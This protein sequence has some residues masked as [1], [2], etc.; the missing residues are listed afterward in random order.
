VTTRADDKLPRCNFLTV[1]CPH[2]GAIVLEH[3]LAIPL[4]MLIAYLRRDR[5]AFAR[6][7]K[8]LTK[9]SG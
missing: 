7:P 6:Y 3:G 8:I 1:Q 9:R 4:F 5:A 2:R